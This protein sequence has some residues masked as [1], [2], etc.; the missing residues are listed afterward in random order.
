MTFDH[1][2]RIFSK[3]AEIQ[4]TCQRITKILFPLAIL[5]SIAFFVLIAVVFAFGSNYNLARLAYFL[6]FTYLSIIF[7]ASATVKRT[8]GDAICEISRKWTEKEEYR[9]FKYSQMSMI[10]FFPF[11]LIVTFI[12]NGF[13][14]MMIMC[15]A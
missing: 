15:A 12:A 4:A 8:I 7:A 11:G 5:S 14:G 10:V 9:T 1:I 13:L 3:I 6:E 2:Q